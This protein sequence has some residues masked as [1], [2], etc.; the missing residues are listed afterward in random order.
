VASPNSISQITEAGSAAAEPLR[1]LRRGLARADGFALYIAIVKT[2]A[3][4]NQLITLLGEALPAVKLQTVTIGREATDI[5]DEIH[6]QLGGQIAGPVM[7]VGFED[8]LSSDTQSH[9]ILNSLNLRRPDWP[10]RVPQPVVFWLPEYLLGLFARSAPDFLDW[11]SDTLHFPDLEP[12]QL[13]AMHSATWDRGLDTRMPVGARLERVKE[14]ESRIT[15]NEH[16]EDSVIRSTVAD[17]LNELGLHLR[18]L[19]RTQEALKCF[20]K[21]LALFHKLGDRQGENAVLGNLGNAYAAL[22]DA[23]KA[24]EFHE[25]SLLIAC[26]IGDRR[27]EG[28]ALGNLG[29]AHADL[30]DARKVIKFYEQSLVIKREIGNRRGEGNALMNLG[31]AYD[32]LGDARKAIEF[33]EQALTVFREVGDRRGEGNALMNLG[34]GYDALGDARKAIE[35]HKQALTVF[36]EI[37]DRRGKGNALGN[38]GVAYRSLGDVRKAIEFYEQH[39]DIAREIGD[40]RGEGSALW[41]SA[42]DHNSLGNRAEAIARAEAALKIFEAIENPSVAK[43]RAK[44]AEWRAAKP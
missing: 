37:G 23:R 12:S 3:Q 21:C 30:G 27:G 32:A 17:W 9:P 5:L 11:R 43:V 6:R 38:L 19:G 10:Q 33:H 26:E 35:F 20:E 25:Q 2:P 31:N 24:I 16:N 42:L 14:L 8:V 34:N 36:R 22:G 4:R 39:R 18:L 40:R 7:V 28:N 44:L 1:A 29:N 15:A 13:Q 41:N